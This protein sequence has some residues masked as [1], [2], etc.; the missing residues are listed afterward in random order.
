MRLVVISDIHVGSG[1][2]DD[3]D[4]ELEGGLVSFWSS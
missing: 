2:L 1:P 3:C 4:A